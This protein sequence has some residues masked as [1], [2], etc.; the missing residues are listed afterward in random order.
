MASGQRSHGVLHEK[1]QAFGGEMDRTSIHV[2]LTI[3]RF[4][5]RSP[6]ILVVLIIPA[7]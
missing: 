7:A 5:K 3:P 1:F 6:T 2:P 4:A